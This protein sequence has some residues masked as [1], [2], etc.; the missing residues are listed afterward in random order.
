MIIWMALPTNRTGED[1]SPSVGT[2][3]LMTFHD[4]LGSSIVSRVPGVLL[5]NPMLGRDVQLIQLMSYQFPPQFMMKK[6]DEKSGSEVRTSS[7]QTQQTQLSPG[8]TLFHYIL[9]S[10]QLT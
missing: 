4:S 1:P 3:E 10:G 7:V 6:E 2:C 5:F 8:E 9:P